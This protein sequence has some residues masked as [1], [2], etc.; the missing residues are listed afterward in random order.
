MRADLDYY[1]RGYVRISRDSVNGLDDPM[2]HG[3]D[4]VYYKE[5][6]DPPY[7]VVESKYDSSGLSRL[8]D[9]TRQMSDRWIKDR[10]EDAVGETKAKEI[11]DIGYRRELYRVRPDGRGGFDSYTRQVGEDG[12]VVRGSAGSVPP[13][14]RG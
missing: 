10:L 5:G 8:V 13:E 2:H 11:Q 4:A 7:I 9:G 3:I 12:Y 6:G 1:E 14:G